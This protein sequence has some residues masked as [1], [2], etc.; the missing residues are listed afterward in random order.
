MTSF[1]S[2]QGD[3]ILFAVCGLSPAVLTETVWALAHES[4][5]VV[6][7]RVVVLTT[8]SGRQRIR[9]QLL[10]SGVWQKLRRRL[11][12]SSAESLLFGDSSDSIRLFPSPQ[13][14][15][16]LDE[17]TTPEDN[18]TAAD[19]ILENLRQFT[20]IPD[21]RIVASVAGGR[22]TMSVL[23]ALCLTL[24]GRQ[25]D[26]LCHVLVNPPFDAPDLDPPF[27]FPDEDVPIHHRAQPDGA[28]SEVCPS[29]A[30]IKLV[31][32]P[33]IQLRDVL[34]GGGENLPY[35]YSDLVE[36]G[37]ENIR[38]QRPPVSLELIAS[39]VACR[40]NGQSIELNE[41][42]FVTYYVLAE[43]CQKGAE[44]LRGTT[45]LYEAVEKTLAGSLISGNPRLCQ[46]ADM[47]RGKNPPDMRKVVSSIATKLSDVLGTG[48]VF[49]Q[50]RPLQPDKRGVYGVQLDAADITIQ[51]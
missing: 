37:R 44:P 7:G 8:E 39:S 24:L 15:R 29:E 32:I 28:I 34:P 13:R 42:E 30:S 47:F 50:C 41:L 12:V 3:T 11:G 35:R 40:V 17:L 22:K 43:R 5:P 48:A 10:D 33:F 46:A 2:T 49:E 4:P 20:E 19:F 25:K 9:E 31:D 14:D 51:P 1:A 21:T 38:R 26:R 18:H 23:A 45:K 6:P 27:Y 36:M 16:N